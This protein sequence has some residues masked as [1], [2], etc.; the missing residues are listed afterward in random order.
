MS[1]ADI[2]LSIVAF[3]ASAVAS[4][5]VTSQSN[6]LRLAVL[7]RVSPGVPQ[8]FSMNGVME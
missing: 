7:D 4:W 5:T 8:K 3:S 2:V 1:F 6:A